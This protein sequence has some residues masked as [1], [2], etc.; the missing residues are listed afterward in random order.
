VVLRCIRK[1]TEQSSK[2]QTSKQHSSMASALVSAFRSLSQFPSVM[3][4]ESCFG[5]GVYH[6]NRRSKVGSIRESHLGIIMVDREG[7]TPWKCQGN[8]L[9]GMV[10]N[11]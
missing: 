10:L 1:Q 7:L 4:C 9:K 8:E 2:E 11:F 5:H 3:E 6:S